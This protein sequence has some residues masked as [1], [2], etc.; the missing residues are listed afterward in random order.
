MMEGFFPQNGNGIFGQVILGGLLGCMY[1]THPDG[2]NGFFHRKALAAACLFAPTC[3]PPHVMGRGAGRNG[4]L[5]NEDH[6][7][8]S[9][10]SDQL[11]L[12]E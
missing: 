11:I 5:I 8:T 6:L 7:L 9:L 12:A 3:N 4:E 1:P 2:G 10:Q